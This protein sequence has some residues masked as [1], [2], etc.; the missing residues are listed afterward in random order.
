MLTGKTI[1]RAACGHMLI[2]AALITILVAKVYHIPLHTK[3]TADSK[4]NTASTDSEIGDEETRYTGQQ[5][6]AVDVT[7]DITEAK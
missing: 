4:W 5:Q 3:D 2:Y 6:G 1:S 7:S